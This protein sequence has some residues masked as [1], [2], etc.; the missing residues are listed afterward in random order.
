MRNF[1]DLLHCGRLVFLKVTEPKLLQ[2][3]HGFDKSQI[4]LILLAFESV[5]L[6][7]IGKRGLLAMMVMMQMVMP[8]LFVFVLI[9]VFDVV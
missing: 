1:L 7:L 6:L 3:F 4:N 5:D 2:D 8:I 9:W